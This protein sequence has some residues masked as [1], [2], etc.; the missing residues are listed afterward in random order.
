[1][2]GPERRNIYWLV[3][4]MSMTDITTLR[5]PDL[6]VELDERGLRATGLKAELLDRLRSACEEEVDALME[7]LPPAGPGAAVASPPR[8]ATR[9]PT[10]NQ[11]VSPAAVKKTKPSR[12]EARRAA[13]PSRCEALH[14]RVARLCTEPLAVAR[15]FALLDVYGHG[16]VID[17]CLAVAEEEF[18]EELATPTVGELEER[19]ERCQDA[20]TNLE[21]H[22][23][24]TARARGRAAAA[25]DV[26]AWD[27]RGTAPRTC[28]GRSPAPEDARA[29]VG[30]LP[31]PADV[32]PT[33]QAFAAPPAPPPLHVRQRQEREALM[34]DY[35]SRQASA[36]ERE[37]LGEAARPVLDELRRRRGADAPPAGLLA[38][39]DPA[40]LLA[41]AEAAACA[42]GVPTAALLAASIKSPN[43]SDF[44]LRGYHYEEKSEEFKRWEEDFGSGVKEVTPL[45]A[46][47]SL[48]DAVAVATLLQAGA[49]LHRGGIQERGYSEYGEHPLYGAFYGG[50][51]RSTEARRTEAAACVHALLDAWDGAPLDAGYPD[52]EGRARRRGLMTF[53][54]SER[55]PMSD[56][57]W[58]LP[59]DE[60]LAV[61]KRLK[62]LGARVDDASDGE[63]RPIHR[64]CHKGRPKLIAWLLRE[65][66][67]PASP[68]AQWEFDEEIGI[69]RPEPNHMGSPLE[70]C[71]EQGNDD[72]AALIRAALGPAP[73]PH[74]SPPEAYRRDLA[75]VR[76]KFTRWHD[77]R[78]TDDA[79]VNAA[80]ERLEE[81]F[82]KGREAQAA[83]RE[84]EL[85]AKWLAWEKS[86]EGRAYYAG[87][88][89]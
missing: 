5:V 27:A 40:G 54:R 62:A 6:R 39:A 17:E 12:D 41:S 84:P 19:L 86:E 85:N 57:A 44:S 15:V 21:G 18:E 28:V 60:G 20:L 83:R 72:C 43:S 87:G 10:H 67:D 11:G 35:E 22:A 3:S 25:E 65:G 82:F 31:T 36:A 4:T 69:E 56:V 78:K 38:S 81:G 33:I 46:A 49:P 66:A 51:P 48:G 13:P 52:E 71:E 61:A 26:R 64:A 63:E 2:H 9:G 76:T 8:A 58:W 74:Y 32:T 47:C 23:S 70:V 14:A 24:T 75:L 77:F 42:A 16:D 88:D 30:R 55:S 80:N 45:Y 29:A 7:E 34:R 53:K 59:D 79:A 50:G 68:G 89:Y 37:R 73:P 1:M